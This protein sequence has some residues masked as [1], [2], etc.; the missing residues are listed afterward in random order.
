MLSCVRQRLLSPERLRRTEERLRELAAREARKQQPNG[1]LYDKRAALSALK[2]ELVKIAR[3]LALAE[4]PGQYKAV[5]DIFEQLKKREARAEHEVTV[6]ESATTD[7]ND[8][9]QAIRTGMQ[10][11]HQLAELA[12]DPD[13]LRS[14]GEIFR[15]VN[16]RLFLGFRSV[17]RK[18]RTVDKMR[19]G[20]VTFGDDPPPIEIYEGGGNSGSTGQLLRPTV[21]VA[22]PFAPRLT[23]WL[24]KSAF[25]TTRERRSEP[26]SQHCPPTSSQTP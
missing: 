9:E 26:A 17:K 12:S 22:C 8:V 24:G 21:S 7:K 16:A 20:V 2:K 14:A 13:C 1:K 25:H 15:L 3:N 11:V 23:P 10:V 18:K 5:A 6:A 4:S 19:G